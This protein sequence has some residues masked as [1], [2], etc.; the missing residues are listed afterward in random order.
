[1][2]KATKRQVPLIVEQHPGDYTW[3]PFITLIQYNKESHLTVVDNA[4]D[5][6]ISAFVL[7]LCGPESIDQ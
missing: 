3:L 2:E 1:M 5:K 6:T 7:D 4:E